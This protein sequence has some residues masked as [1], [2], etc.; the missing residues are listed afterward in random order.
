MSSVLSLRVSYLTWAVEAEFRKFCDRMRKWKTFDEYAL[1]T[2]DAHTPPPREEMLRRAELLKVRIAE[3][4]RR[5]PAGTR[6]GINQLCTLGHVDEDAGFARSHRGRLF[7]GLKSEGTPGNFCP[8]DPVWL[9][10]YVEPVYRALAAVDPDFLWIDDDVRLHN[11][12]KPLDNGCF[13]EACFARICAEL[14]FTGTRDEFAAWFDAG[15]WTQRRERRLRLLWI[16]RRTLSGLLAFIEQAVHAVKP[17]L[18]LGRM[19]CPDFWESDRAA[20]AALLRGPRALP[21]W[22]RPGGGLYADRVPESLVDKADSIGAIVAELPGFVSSIQS[23]I[24]N[25]P[26]LRLAKSNRFNQL[27]VE[28]YCAVGCTGAALNILNVS[29]DPLDSFEERILTF[30]RGRAFT[31]KIVDGNRG[32]PPR[33]IWDGVD[34]DYFLGA[35]VAADA[36]WLNASPGGEGMRGGELSALGLPRAYALEHAVCAALESSAAAALSEEKLLT[37]LA[38]G[39]YLDAGAVAV[40]CERGFGR[41]LGFVPAEQFKRDAMETLTAHRLNPVCEAAGAPYRRNLRQSFWG[42]VAT[43]FTPLPGAQILA[44]LCDYQGRELAPCVMGCFENELG[45]RVAVSGYGAWRHLGYVRKYAQLHTLFRYLSGDALDGEV[46]ECRIR[47]SLWVRRD[48]ESGGLT[49]ALLNTS[50]DGVRQLQLRL[51]TGADEL[52]ISRNG[53]RDRVVSAVRRE[54]E[55]AEFLLPELAALELAYLQTR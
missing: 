24:E 3:L 7:R 33:G 52:I 44:G 1:F 11:H 50:L 13:C 23:E 40:L 5:L 37:L 14:G 32:L 39:L 41:Y 34:A 30:R 26:Y 43:S 10:E 9:Q 47:S 49:A 27:E 17:E 36:P 18:V 45:G 42:G 6:I 51:R 29:P 38:R 46:P 15:D 31:D 8:C 28:T 48:P 35:G 54:G 16:N 25:F 2:H 21:V 22:W 4:R 19:D 12:G 55:F 53:R 20:Q